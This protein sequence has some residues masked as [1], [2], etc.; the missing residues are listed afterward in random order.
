MPWSPGLRGSDG[1]WD[2]LEGPAATITARRRGP[3]KPKGPGGLPPENDPLGGSGAG[4]TR[5]T[6]PRIDQRPGNGADSASS[7]KLAKRRSPFS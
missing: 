3:R 1:P 6:D 7:T 5:T 4:P 2:D